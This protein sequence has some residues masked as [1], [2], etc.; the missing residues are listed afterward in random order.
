MN[1]NSL[2]LGGREIEK[3]MT[4]IS[5]YSVLLAAIL[6]IVYVSPEQGACVSQ[7][8]VHILTSK[9]LCQDGC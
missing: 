8:R 2:L 1:E 9:S 7:N 6:L 3:K 4:I 5:A